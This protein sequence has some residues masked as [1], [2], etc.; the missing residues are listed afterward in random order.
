MRLDKFFSTVTALSRKECTDK[1][2]KGKA[3]V[4]GVTIKKPDAKI[5]PEKDEIFL[6]GKQILYRPYLYL[7]LN[8][9]EG[10]VSATED[11]ADKTVLD[12]L[13]EEYKKFNL[14]PCGRLDKDT[15]GFVLLTNDGQAAHRALA[16]RSHVEKEYEFSLADPFTEEDALAVE[17]G[18]SLADGYVT[19]P[20]RIA[21]TG[22]NTGVITLTEGKYH[23]IKRMFAA[24]GNKI[25]FLKRISF[26][27]IPLDPSLKEGEWRALT[28][29]ET[30]KFLSPKKGSTL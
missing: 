26:A 2:K 3:A 11:K 29:K 7:M 4:N 20:C 24:R 5:D 28:E 18:V 13:P 30:A 19:K 8:K 23:E 22:D 12:L 25:V 1:I 16:P 10:V 15:L 27:G 9:P 21:R 14:F 17:R 6:D